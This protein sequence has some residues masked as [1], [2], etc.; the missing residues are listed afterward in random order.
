M[1]ENG[2]Y[3]S[4]VVVT[5]DAIDATSGIY[6]TR[7]MIDSG[8]WNVGDAFTISDDGIHTVEYYSVDNAGNEEEHHSIV[9]KID[10]TDPVTTHSLS[11][12]MGENGWYVSDVDVTLTATDETS[13]VDYTMYRIDGGSWRGYTGTFTVST[14]GT[15]KVDYYSVD[16]AGNRESTKS[17]SFKIDQTDPVTTHSLSGEMGENDWYVSDVEVTL[18]AIDATSGID[19][20]KYRIDGG[21]WQTYTAPFT[22][23]I[24]GEHTVDYYSVDMAGNEE[25]TKTVLFKI[26]QTNPTVS[27]DR[28]GGYL[29]IFD[30]Q[31]IPLPFG[32][33]IIIGQITIKV[34]ATDA[35]SE[36]D[37]VEFYIDGVMENTDPDEPYEWTWDETVFFKH[38]IKVMAYD[39]AGNV[40]IPDEIEV[41]IFNIKI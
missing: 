27:I 1:G 10:T 36:I 12:E 13:G 25:S 34:V 7:Y 9:I 30:R 23:S 6:E 26:D 37:R 19:E 32:K 22:V 2:W 29:Y 8:G 38:T 40:A 35:M 3:V 14:D 31:I 24:D 5:L 39:K 11:G 15:H 21:S 20:T 4:S 16:N 33:T 28:P 18:D 17:V 41:M